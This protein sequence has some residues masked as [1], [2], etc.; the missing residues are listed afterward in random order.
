M[1]SESPSFELG[2]EIYRSCEQLSSAVVRRR[3]TI[4]SIKQLAKQFTKRRKQTKQLMID[5][6]TSRNYAYDTFIRNLKKLEFV[7][8]SNFKFQSEI[9][10]DDLEILR[11]KINNDVE[12]W[13]EFFRVL[14]E[15]TE[16]EVASESSEVGE[17]IVEELNFIDK[18]NEVV[19][20][21]SVAEDEI[22]LQE[23]RDKDECVTEENVP[24]NI[25]S[26]E[27]TPTSLHSLQNM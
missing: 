8:R 27:L 22:Q 24:L 13:K 1:L 2:V 15:G 10:I 5:K 20:N 7:R 26:R 9:D 3:E 4:K 17:E 18:K 21:V 14:V 25:L 19:V 11:N 23:E 6:T 16:W 12:K